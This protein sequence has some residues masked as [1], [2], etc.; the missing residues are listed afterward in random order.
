M[1]D[2]PNYVDALLEHLAN[3]PLGPG[4]HHVEVRHDDDCPIFDGRPCDCE[5][6]I[7]SGERVDEKYGD[8][9]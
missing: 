4:V 3:S 7:E 9:G 5:P 2:R 6:E 8:E 1:T